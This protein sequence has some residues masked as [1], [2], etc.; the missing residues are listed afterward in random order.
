[1]DLALAPAVPDIQTASAEQVAAFLANK[2]GFSRI[3]MD[4][5]R[6]MLFEIWNSS[7]ELSDG[8]GEA[9]ARLSSRDRGQVRIAAMQVA[10]DHL[11]RAANYVAVAGCDT[12]HQA[13]LARLL[14]ARTGA[15][16]LAAGDFMPRQQHKVSAGQV[17]F[18]AI[19]SLKWQAALL[20]RDRWDA[21]SLVVSD[22]CFHQLPSLARATLPA[23]QHAEFLLHK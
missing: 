22:F 18:A 15:R 12:V 20:D 2:R 11:E 10:M 5:R 7:Q 14:A 1:M 17:P 19:E 3:P 8:M 23:A 9:F 4:D 13:E 6:K 21:G 16:L